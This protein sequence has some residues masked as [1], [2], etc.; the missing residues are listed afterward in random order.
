MLGYVDRD[1]RVYQNTRRFV[2]SPENPYYMFGPV[3][4]ATGGPHIGPGM[5]WPMALIVQ[6]LTSNHDG[7]IEMGI[8]QL[9][10]ST[11]DKGL[12]HES[13]HSHDQRRWTRS[14]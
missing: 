4:N 8:R 12:M 1:D 2:L 6:I 13:I 7:E 10:A 3:L 14:W 5:A 11:D 9:L